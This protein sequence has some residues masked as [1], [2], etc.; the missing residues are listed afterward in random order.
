MCGGCQRTAPAACIIVT[1]LLR[2]NTLRRPALSTAFP[3]SCAR[4]LQEPTRRHVHGRHGRQCRLPSP[5]I[6]SLSAPAKHRK[7]TYKTPKIF[8]LQKKPAT[9]VASTCRLSLASAAAAPCMHTRL[10]HR[11]LVPLSR[12]A[13]KQD[14]ILPVFTKGNQ[15]R[16]H[17]SQHH[18]D[19][20]QTSI[21]RGPYPKR[22]C[23]HPPPEKSCLLHAPPHNK[24]RLV[25]A[26]L[27]R[28][29]PR[30]A[31]TLLHPRCIQHELHVRAFDV[32]S[33][34]YSHPQL[35]QQLQ[36]PPAALASTVRTA[37]ATS[38]YVFYP[39]PADSPRATCSRSARTSASSAATFSGV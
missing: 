24:R 37:K 35:H 34:G 3:K 20:C 11:Q 18:F 25:C 7:C 13:E 19:S 30:H 12:K 36:S 9:E 4:G 1:I 39:R 33:T 27:S 14:K 29:R 16:Y 31:P 6:V 38:R 21:Y 17:Q 2:S 28:M 26:Y 22:N 5:L 23:S 8:S 10:P 32:H 15:A